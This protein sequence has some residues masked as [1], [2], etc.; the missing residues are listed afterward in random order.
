MS[1]RTV[2]NSCRIC[3]GH[4]RIVKN[5]RLC[6]TCYA[7]SYYYYY[8]NVPVTLKPVP[9]YIPVDDWNGSNDDII[10]IIENQGE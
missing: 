1:I 3:G 4:D 9:K 5:T 8:F 6:H 7:I 2:P 10:R